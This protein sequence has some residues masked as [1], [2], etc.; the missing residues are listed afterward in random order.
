VAPQYDIFLKR[1]DG[2]F[3]WVESAEDI[4]QA[5]KRL[6]SLASSEPGNYR[7]WDSGL[8]R[9]IRPFEEYA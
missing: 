2:S 3:V 8:Q 6:I 5:K 1:F 4:H 7:I 9:F